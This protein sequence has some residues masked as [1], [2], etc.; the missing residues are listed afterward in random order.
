[1]AEPRIYLFPP[2]QRTGTACAV[3]LTHKANAYT[4]PVLLPPICSVI[5]FVFGISIHSRHIAFCFWYHLYFQFC[6][7]KNQRACC[8]HTIPKTKRHGTATAPFVPFIPEK[9]CRKLL[10]HNATL[11]I[12]FAKPSYSYVNMPTLRLVYNT[13]LC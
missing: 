1:M 10:K 7:S 13:P 4:A 2:S 9:N 6:K 11:Y 5:L 3:L 8:Q 12:R